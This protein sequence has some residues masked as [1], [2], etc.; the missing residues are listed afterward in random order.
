MVFFLKDF[1]IASTYLFKPINK[2]M[3]KSSVLANMSS[4]SGEIFQTR[5]GKEFKMEYDGGNTFNVYPSDRQG[6][7]ANDPHIC[8]VSNIEKTI[9]LVNSGSISLPTTPIATISSKGVT[10]SASYIVGL[11]TDPRIV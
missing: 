7:P 5:T 3:K 11:L 6:R 1:S 4:H 2:T 10:A 9:N 8:T